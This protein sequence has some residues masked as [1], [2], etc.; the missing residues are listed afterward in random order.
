MNKNPGLKKCGYEHQVQMTNDTF[1][2][3]ELNGTT[4]TIGVNLDK[5][6]FSIA[7]FRNVDLGKHDFVNI[8]LMLDK[9][10]RVQ[11]IKTNNVIRDLQL[12]VQ[13]RF[14]TV[15]LCFSMTS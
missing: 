8:I 10:V 7:K 1:F 6:V 12:N 15:K 3:L 11:S 4:D 9:K 13:S 2:S 14:F 5:S